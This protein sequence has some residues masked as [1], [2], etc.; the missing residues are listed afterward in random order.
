MNQAWPETGAT[1]LLQSVWFNNS[2]VV[3]ILLSN[4]QTDINQLDHEGVTPVTL[5]AQEGYSE[6]L[7]M[8]V[9]HDARLGLGAPGTSEGTPLLIAAQ[10]GHV[11]IINIL[12]YRKRNVDSEL[13]LA[14]V[15]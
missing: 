5:A 15:W 8:L 6:I 2:D 4:N 10:N 9:H 1:P 3:Q 14:S 7:S 13:S 11:N 12:Q